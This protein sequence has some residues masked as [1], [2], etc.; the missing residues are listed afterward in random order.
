M[1]TPAPRPVGPH[2]VSLIL[3]VV[4]QRIPQLMSTYD[5]FPKPWEELKTGRIWRDTDIVE[6]AE[7]HGR[8]THRW[9]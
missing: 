2:E 9:D 7:L 1:T 3:G 8:K 5:D 4:R 6:W